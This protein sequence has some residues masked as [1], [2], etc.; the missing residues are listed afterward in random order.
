MNNSINPSMKYYDETKEFNHLKSSGEKIELAISRLENPYALSDEAML[1]YQGYLFKAK[2]ADVY[3]FI[4]LNRIA[5]FPL[6]VKYRV[7]KKANISQLV[8]YAQNARKLDIL[9]YL[10]NVT[11]DF[12]NHPKNMNIIPKFVSGQERAI[13][14]EQL[15]SYEKIEKG[16]ILWFGKSP[17]P[18]LVLDKK[19]KK[20]LII[21]KY[22]FDCQPYNF[23][24]EHTTWANCTLRKWLN[25][26][27]VES[28]FNKDEEQLIS[29]VY[30]DT[31]DILSLE[32]KDTAICDKVFL[33]SIDEAKKYFKTD[34]ERKARV[35]AY[36]S[37]R[38][39][40]TFFDEYGHW[41][42]RSPS[43][44]TIG[45]TYVKSYG[46]VLN[47]GG[48]IIS[49]GYWADFEH[50]GVRPAIYLDLA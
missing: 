27:F 44:E 48:T 14:N 37:K 9:S 17:M 24:Y 31:N 49:N 6:L 32:K 1:M 12:R 46:P 5:I 10:L 50:F 19:D 18:W 21:S 45:A 13:V 43:V 30:I 20:A 26:D 25:T 11:N 41:W 15:P 36:A 28:I 16:D 22:A 40:W 47:Y 33:L 39:M 4:D 35:T 34:E 3:E 8:D 42:L 38:A 29:K 2:A 7:I 23:R